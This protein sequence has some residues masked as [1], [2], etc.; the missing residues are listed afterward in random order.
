MKQHVLQGLR[1]QGVSLALSHTLEFTPR[2]VL[3]KAPRPRTRKMV[4]AIVGDKT[5]DRDR[6]KLHY[7]SEQAKCQGVALF[8]VTVGSYYNRTEVEH[9]A[10]TPLEQHL[11]HLGQ[12]RDDDQEY[13]QRFFRAFLAVFNGTKA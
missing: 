3:L 4:L 12:L 10:S 11:L 8:V 2:E 7:V 6:A 13:A 5:L 9:L 1:Q